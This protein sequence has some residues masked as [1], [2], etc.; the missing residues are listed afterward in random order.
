[1]A[2]TLHDVATLAGV[3]IKTVSNVVNDYK[4]IRP[5]TREKVLAA[6]DTLGYQPNISARSLRSGKTGVIGLALPELSLSYFAELADAVIRAAERR[7]LVVL[8]EQT[9]GGD[10]ER[11]I[12]MLSSPRL[13][14][15]DGL[16]FSPL[17]MSSDDV[18]YLNVSYPLVLLG[19]R[20]FGGPTDHVTMRNVEAA[21]AAT[22]HLIARGRTR[23]A[24]I[25]A[26]EGEVVGSAALRL[27]GY[28]DALAEAGIEPDESLIRYVGLWHRL[29]GAQAMHEL[30]DSGVE[31]DAVFGL[32]DTLALGAMRVL[33]ES[34]RRIPDDVAVI[35][36]DGLDETK[37]SLPTLSTVD[38]GRDE[39]ADMA[40]DVLVERIANRDAPPRQYLTD[41]SVIGRESTAD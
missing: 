16:I 22:A 25:G 4:H 21:K 38:P 18:G 8:I 3:S 15:T 33:Q 29:D 35:G 31:F 24:V 12:E 23:I 1:M 34:G 6:I 2:V 13:Q 14:L 17:G 27:R 26:H 11:E 30:L 40:V 39:I 5:T 9:A 37:Y 28:L 41:F 10:R 20:I 32:N 7:H 36:F 19:E